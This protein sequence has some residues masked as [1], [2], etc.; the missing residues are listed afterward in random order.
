[1]EFRQIQYFLSVVDTGSFSLAADEHYIGQSSLSKMIISLEKELGVSLFDRSKRKIFLTAAGEAFLVHARKINDDYKAMLADLDGYK[2]AKDYFSIAAI[3]VLSEYGIIASIAQFREKHP[4]IHINLE[5]I[6]GLNILPAL[7]EHRF[8]L[9]I[10]RHN[11][12]DQNHYISLEI[13]KDRFLVAISKNNRHAKRASISL[14][15]LSSDNFIVFDKITELNRLIMDECQKAGFEPTI[16]YSS[17][18]KVSV[19]GLVGTNIGVALIPSIIYEF[20]K[21][22]DVLAVPLEENIEC[23]IV[24]VHPKNRPLPIAASVFMD[25]MRDNVAG[26][27]P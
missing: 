20:H 23:S 2:S 11:Y 17:H 15:D 5:E 22:P 6:D 24:L 25:F 18:Q 16:F 14:K 26:K 10:T 27:N 3:P 9:A 8:D 1:M 7:D 12:V 21:Q 13:Y 19:L 4:D